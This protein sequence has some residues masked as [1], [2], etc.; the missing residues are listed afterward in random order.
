MGVKKRRTKSCCFHGRGKCNGR[1]FVLLA[2]V[3]FVVVVV[4]GASLVRP[5]RPET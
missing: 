2:V 3:V 4:G 1:V 5:E